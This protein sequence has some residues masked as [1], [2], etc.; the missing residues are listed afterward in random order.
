[1]KIVILKILYIAMILFGFF[2]I[3]TFI[4]VSHTSTLKKIVLIA[5]AIGIIL[6]GISGILNSKKSSK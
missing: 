2:G 5:I 1:M 3:Y 6:S 4:F